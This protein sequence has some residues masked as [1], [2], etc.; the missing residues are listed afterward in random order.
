MNFDTT[1][2]CHLHLQ[3]FKDKYLERLKKDYEDKQ[4]NFNGDEKSLDKA[5][6]LYLD[7]NG[8]VESVEALIEENVILKNNIQ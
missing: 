8:L 2:N 1:T 5:R 4:R 7:F 6:R 3:N